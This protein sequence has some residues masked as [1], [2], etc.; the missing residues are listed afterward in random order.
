MTGLSPVQYELQIVRVDVYDRTTD[1]TGGCELRAQLGYIIALIAINVGALF[2]ALIQAWQARHLS[3]EF[4]ESRYIFKASLTIL[5]LLL[6]GVPV[7]IIASDNA[8]ARLFVSG[9]IVFAFCIVVLLLMFVPKIRYEKKKATP[10]ENVRV[11]G[12]FQVVPNTSQISQLD[13]DDGDSLCLNLGERII[14]TKTAEE[15]AMEVVSLRKRLNA[16]KMMIEVMSNTH[17]NVGESN[18][19][20]LVDDSK[21]DNRMSSEV[22]STDLVETLNE[23]KP[24]S[25]S[26]EE[27]DRPVSSSISSS[28]TGKVGLHPLR[29]D[30]TTT[31]SADGVSTTKQDDTETIADRESSRRL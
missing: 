16:Q 17:P 11:S 27:T 24:V 9:S 10:E 13:D 14:T 21:R 22:V 19:N 18:A 26:A 30:S 12:V 25:G 3:T 20:C 7:L 4:A 15:L 5:L 31:L 6:V 2:S 29:V 8:D 1:I 28:E 23:Q